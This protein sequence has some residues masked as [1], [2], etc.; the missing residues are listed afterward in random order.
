MLLFLGGVGCPWASGWLLP[1]SCWLV[2]TKCPQC[3]IRKL[4]VSLVCLH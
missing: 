3:G 2:F 4:C 1:Q